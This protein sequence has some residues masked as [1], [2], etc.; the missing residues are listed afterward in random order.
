MTPDRDISLVSDRDFD[1]IAGGIS[2]NREYQGWYRRILEIDFTVVPGAFDAFAKC[3]RSY[4]T[5]PRYFTS[6]CRRDKTRG[7]SRERCFLASARRSCLS[8]NCE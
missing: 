2:V 5:Y 7:A 4:S 6:I 3:V 8:L 1:D